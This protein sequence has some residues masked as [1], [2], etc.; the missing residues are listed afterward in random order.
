MSI[1]LQI[2]VARGPQGQGAQCSIDLIAWNWG[3]TSPPPM[4]GGGAGTGRMDVRDLSVTKYIDSVSPSLLEYCVK[5]AHL[6]KVALDIE[7]AGPNR[8]D[9]LRSLRNYL[10]GGRSTPGTG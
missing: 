10:S 3:L 8:S 5:G 2:P 1:K 7:E 6:D 4:V 9:H